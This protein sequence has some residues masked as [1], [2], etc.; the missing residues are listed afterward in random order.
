MAGSVRGQGAG[1]F[2]CNAKRRRG[3]NPILARMR[4]VMWPEQLFKPAAVLADPSRAVMLAAL[5]D[6]V[7]LPAGEL[8][9]L[10]GVGAP[11]ASAHL[12]RLMAEGFISVELQG[13][14]R[15][16]RLANAEIG[17]ALEALAAMMPAPRTRTRPCDA[18]MARARLCYHHLAG[19]LGVRLR[20][21]LLERDWLRLDGEGCALSEQGRTALCRHDLVVAGSRAP[22]RGKLCLDWSERRHHVG[23]A[24]GCEL[25]RGLIDRLGW[26]RRQSRSRA[27]LPTPAGRIGLR[28]VF[29]IELD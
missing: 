16:Y 17:A 24:L 25:A 26:L 27:L 28:R 5:L 3:A 1:M 20:E 19:T 12:A 18:D 2:R 10:A 23:G 11:A 22:A 9:R 8:A 4:R 7:A 6:G 15:Y 21:A 29:A 13:R 14:H